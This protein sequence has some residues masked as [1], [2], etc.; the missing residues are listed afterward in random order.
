M[1]VILDNAADDLS[2][3][4]KIAMN[5]LVTLTIISCQ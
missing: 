2:V 1:A 3:N 5:H 4:L